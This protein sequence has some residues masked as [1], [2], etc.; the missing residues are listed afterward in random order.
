MECLKVKKGN[1][2]AISYHMMNWT[3]LFWL[4]L[5]KCL[6]LRHLTQH[7]Q[8]LVVQKPGVS[9]YKEVMLK[10]LDDVQNRHARQHKPSGK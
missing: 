6:L 2:W 7:H 10:R 9:V 8:L 1:L 4:Q 3:T 5:I